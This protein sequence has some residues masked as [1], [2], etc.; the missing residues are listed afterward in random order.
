[1]SETFTFSAKEKKF[2]LIAIVA[3]LV[4][5][6]I[7]AAM[8]I[9]EPTRIYTGLLY[10]NFYFLF[11]AIAALFFIAANTIGYGGWYIAVRR[12]F[13]AIAGYIP[14]GGVLMLPILAL[15]MHDIYH[16]THEGLI[17]PASPHYDELIAGKAPYLNTGFFWARTIIYIVLWTVFAV[18]I[19]R[20]S[21]NSEMN[22]SLSLY[23]QSKYISAAYI[24][25]FAV[26][27]STSSWDFL[28]SIQP[29]WYSTLFGWYCFISAFVSVMSVVMLITLYLQEQGYLK[30]VTDEH[31]HDLGKFM[32]G[33][34]IAW[35]YL[36]FAQFM[37]IWYSNIPEETL[38]YKLRIEE[39]PIVLYLCVV[40][41]F[42]APFFVLM[43]RGNKRHRKTVMFIALIII[44]GHW[45]DFYQMAVPGAI[46]NNAHG[47]E[48]HHPHFVGLLEIGLFIFY[49]G[50]F[51]FMTFS[52]LAK[53]PLQVKNHPFH[54][55]SLI[56]HT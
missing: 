36:F 35:G 30:Q 55:E 25:V 49:S 56:H 12:I 52:A 45:L 31:V 6:G 29:H 24:V 14:I 51:S 27:S 19:R 47:H 53:A 38:F 16:W 23:Q 48:A 11:L 13:E 54:K 33:F 4:L 17:D 43:T 32:F 40:F 44:I 22:P 26:S 50:L 39:Y 3:G 37:L 34:S 10:N 46:A 18:V 41:N 9:S 1:M 8:N 42:V 2:S 20:N 15:G 21:L 28:M 5:F 7:G